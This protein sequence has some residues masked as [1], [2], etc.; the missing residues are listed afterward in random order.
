MIEVAHK[1]LAEQMTD[2]VQQLVDSI[3]PADIEKASL[4]DRVVC[5]GILQDKG[6]QSYGL[7]NPAPLVN[8]DLSNIVPAKFDLD[9]YLNR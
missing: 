8:I 9:G 4:R 1:L 6:R 3:K 5:I 2:L 7:D